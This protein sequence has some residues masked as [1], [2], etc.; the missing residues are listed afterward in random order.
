[1]LNH[2]LHKLV[3]QELRFPDHAGIMELAQPAS[4]DKSLLFQ[5]CNIGAKDYLELLE[6]AKI[7]T[8]IIKEV[9]KDGD[10]LLRVPQGT[11]FYSYWFPHEILTIQ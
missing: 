10:F 4:D 5:T 1:M 3:N 2:P 7:H 6:Y 9:D 11:Q 8:V